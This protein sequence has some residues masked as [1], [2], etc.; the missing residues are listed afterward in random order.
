MEL[1][2]SLQSAIDDDDD[3][4]SGGDADSWIAEQGCDDV[5]AALVGAAVGSMRLL[6]IW[7]SDDNISG[8]CEPG[9]WKPTR[10]HPGEK[11]N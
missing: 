1:P 3:E 11:V 6:P 10:L 7:A 4:V 2:P 9:S 8:L 5:T